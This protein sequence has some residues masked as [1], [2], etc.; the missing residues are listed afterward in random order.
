MQSLAKVLG[1][2][3]AVVVLAPS[4]APA[5]EWARKMFGETVHSFGTVARGS[6]AEHRFSF[7]NPYN[8]TI[9]ITGV[10]TSCGCTS[11]VVTKE[12]LKTYETAEVIAKFNT[13]S[14]LG[15]HG[16]TLTVTIDKP[17]PAEVQLRV[18]GNIRSDVS[19]DPPLADLGNVELGSGSERT[20]RVSH[21]GSTPWEISD[22]RSV[23]RAPPGRAPPSR[24]VPRR[25]RSTT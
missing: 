25:R 7:R 12:S 3:A 16:A 15:Q 11:P 23:P 6:K 4:A 21:A 24:R 13:R 1:L 19:F 10:R 17:F 22:V 18:S 20:V 8:E 5:Q 2:V 14:F 9:H